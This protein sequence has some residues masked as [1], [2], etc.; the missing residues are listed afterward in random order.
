M[1]CTGC[2]V[3]CIHIGQ[4]RREFDKGHEYETINASYDHE[5]IFA[6]GSF[7]GTNTAA[8]VLELID[9]AEISGMDVMSTGVTLGWAAEAYSRVILTVFATLSTPF[10]SALLALSSNI[11]CFEAICIHLD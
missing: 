2:P 3:G 8:E 1:A 9:Q 4:F 5:L 6:L 11:I 10:K 7:L